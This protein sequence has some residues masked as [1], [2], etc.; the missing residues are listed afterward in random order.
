MSFVEKTVPAGFD[1]TY[2]MATGF[3]TASPGNWKSAARNCV[4][5]L[6]SNA[7]QLNEP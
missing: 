6:Q 5:E 4:A 3:F 2:C 1:G 7:A